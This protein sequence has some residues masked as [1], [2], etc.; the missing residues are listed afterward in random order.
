MLTNGMDDG[1]ARKGSIIA[2]KMLCRSMMDRLAIF[3]TGGLTAESSRLRPEMKRIT[4]GE[5]TD[6]ELRNCESNNRSRAG[7][8]MFIYATPAVPDSFTVNKK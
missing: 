7:L 4:G 5:K 2:L 6:C 8:I 3:V 1:S